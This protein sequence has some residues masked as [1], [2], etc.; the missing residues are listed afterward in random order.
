MKNVIESKG[1]LGDIFLP[2]FCT[3]KILHKKD[4]QVPQ[5]SNK[6]SVCIATSNLLSISNLKFFLDAHEEVTKSGKYNFEGC[7]KN[8]FT[9]H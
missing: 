9:L 7:R 2:E 5:H 3:T 4:F 8:E 6:C 1:Y